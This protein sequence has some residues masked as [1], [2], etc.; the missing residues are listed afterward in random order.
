MF[1]IKQL[2]VTQIND[3]LNNSQSYGKSNIRRTRHINEA[4]MVKLPYAHSTISEL[5]EVAKIKWNVASKKQNRQ[6]INE[7]L[8]ANQLDNVYSQNVKA[9]LYQEPDDSNKR[10]RKRSNNDD[11]LNTGNM[12]LQKSLPNAS[13]Y[14]SDTPMDLRNYK[15]PYQ[16]TQYQYSK[17]YSAE[18][19]ITDDPNAG[20]SHTIPMTYMP[21]SFASFNT[22]TG[23]NYLVPDDELEL[24][25]NLYTKDVYK[26]IR[27]ILTNNTPIVTHSISENSQY[28]ENNVE[29]VF[30]AFADLDFK[31]CRYPGTY[32]SSLRFVIA[33]IMQRVMRR[34]FPEMSDE[35]WD[36]RGAMIISESDARIV[37]SSEVQEQVI[38]K[39]YPPSLFKS[40]S[41]NNKQKDNN[42]T[43][44]NNY[45]RWCMDPL[46]C[47]KKYN[48]NQVN[49]KSQN[50]QLPPSE[51]STTAV[52][53][54]KIILSSPHVTKFSFDEKS[55]NNN[56]NNTFNGFSTLSGESSSHLKTN[57]SIDTSD[58][59]S[60]TSTHV[61]KILTTS[62]SMS[63]TVS[64][65]QLPF[66]LLSTNNTNENKNVS[67]VN[68]QHFPLSKSVDTLHKTSIDT[69]KTRSIDLYNT[70]TDTF[71]TDNSNVSISTNLSGGT[72]T[73][74]NTPNSFSSNNSPF[75]TTYNED[76]MDG[77]DSSYPSRLNKSS[78]S[79]FPDDITD[80]GFQSQQSN[81]SNPTS[82]TTLNTHKLP[83]GLIG[84]LNP[85]TPTAHMASI[86]YDI[87]EQ[88][89]NQKDNS[90]DD[91]DYFDTLATS[92]LNSSSSPYSSL[93][94]STYS[95]SS[96]S[97]NTPCK[98][99]CRLPHKLGMHV[100]F[101]KIKVT[102]DKM[103]LIRLAWIAELTKCISLNHE[104]V[105]QSLI[106]LRP[107]NCFGGSLVQSTN[108]A[109]LENLWSNIIDK[110]VYGKHNMD[111]GQFIPAHLRKLYSRKVKKCTCN[112]QAKPYPSWICDKCY[113]TNYI[114][115]E[116]L[117]SL[118]DVTYM[119]T[120]WGHPHKQHSKFIEKLK[121]KYQ[122]YDGAK[123]SG[124]PLPY[125]SFDWY[126]RDVDTSIMNT[127]LNISPYLIEPNALFNNEYSTINNNNNNNNFQN[128]RIKH[129]F[130]NNYTIA[131]PLPRF[132]LWLV[133]EDMAM[134]IIKQ[135]VCL[136]SIRLKKGDDIVTDG[137]DCSYY[138]PIMQSRD[139]MEP[140]LK[141]RFNLNSTYMLSPT[142]EKTRFKFPSVIFAQQVLENSLQG[143][144]PMKRANSLSTM[145]MIDINSNDYL[146]SINDKDMIGNRGIGAIIQS[147]E[148]L[149]SKSVKQAA[150]SSVSGNYKPNAEY[151]LYDLT[152]CC[153]SIRDAT[154]NNSLTSIIQTI[155]PQ[156]RF[157]VVQEIF[158]IDH[159]ELEKMHL[160]AKKDI[161]NVLS[162]LG[163]RDK[164]S[165]SASS[166][167]LS[168]KENAPKYFT[169]MAIV[170]GRNVNWC[171]N[172]KRLHNSTEISFYITVEG[173]QPVCRSH[174][175]A[176]PP[177]ALRI[178]KET[179][180]GIRKWQL[181]DV[182][183]KQKLFGEASLTVE[184]NKRYKSL[185]SSV[186]TLQNNP[187]EEHNQ[188]AAKKILQSWQNI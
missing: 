58:A 87:N 67:L 103:I 34:F 48:F 43:S 76:T 132:H 61:P 105:G 6:R 187:Y 153:C 109:S 188:L 96:Q 124:A 179:H 112:Q 46:V 170:T 138:M 178:C 111:T 47:A 180:L 22:F 80:V 164:W 102:Y 15:S 106:P 107:S 64:M 90:N 126:I 135:Y 4:L 168:K 92:S 62:N 24:F 42:N 7:K 165:R 40:P 2:N 21:K 26:D 30:P 110:D 158:A 146:N 185:S 94:N 68:K 172:V 115:S 147:Q 160:Q 148:H 20:S 57:Q 95:L 128:D 79:L 122:E 116:G 59:T 14:I 52:D 56:N 65:M 25:Q 12:L 83:F 49:E 162:S 159:K 85:H 55:S 161:N 75:I 155:R 39:Y 69:F 133:K 173:I 11:N 123:K 150:K 163:E 31:Y 54:G 63:K 113:N 100:H 114:D 86:Q 70:S 28:D 18:M 16:G 44:E 5:N 141:R 137:F 142:K 9:H 108:M 23:S 151:H 53:V 10:K 17:V 145:D 19:I 73:A 45:P 51:T 167:L 29:H 60:S 134:D 169:F 144:K 184:E 177:S 156:W 32:D 181:Q 131:K 84:T 77:F 140:F 81:S 91:N 27:S 78:Q 130:I 166:S 97:S 183:I 1:A 88:K 186:S 175:I 82:R 174:S 149:S 74:Y 101:P 143:K 98:N 120:G 3:N 99:I 154:Y 66:P 104:I 121:V 139:D 171:P 89:Y 157:L 117:K 176:L 119:V 72:T 36:K 33:F 71:P 118:Y 93:K 8:L 129:Q 182:L 127:I 50:S 13:L 152:T 37:D 41:N 125:G 35:E 38:S 136:T